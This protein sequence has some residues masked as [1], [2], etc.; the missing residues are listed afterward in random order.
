MYLYLQVQFSQDLNF[1]YNI[2][3]LFKSIHSTFNST[4]SHQNQFSSIFF[5][6][7]R[8]SPYINI[9]KKVGTVLHNVK[10]YVSIFSKLACLDFK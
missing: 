4:N 1:K 10:I 8:F 6:N 2:Q 7:N 3:K 5:F 9:L